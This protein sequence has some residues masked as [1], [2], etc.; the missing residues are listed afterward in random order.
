M[1]IMATSFM[2]KT[3][4]TA[5][6]EHDDWHYFSTKHVCPCPVCV[7]SPKVD[8]YLRMRPD[9]RLLVI[10]ESDAVDWYGIEEGSGDVSKLARIGATLSDG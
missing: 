8:L 9:A 7:K 2:T 10:K 3:Q 1:R 5:L 6:M 4:F